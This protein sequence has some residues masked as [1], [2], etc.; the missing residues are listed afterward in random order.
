M[1]VIATGFEGSETLARKPMQVRERSRAAP[2]RR[3]RRPRAPRAPGLRRRHR[4]PAVPARPLSRHAAIAWRAWMPPRRCRRTPLY[5]AHVAAGAKLVPFAGWEMPVAVRGGPRRAPRGALRLRRLRRLAHGR[6]RDRRARRRSALLQRLLSNDVAK[7]EVGGAQYSVLCREDGG[8]LDDLFTYRLADDRYL[9]VTNAANHERDLAWF[10]E[11]AGDFDAEV[12][13]RLAD[14]AMLAVQ[15]PD[16]RAIVAGLARRRAAAAD[17]HRDAR[18]VAGA[19]ALVCGTGYTGEDGVEILVDAGRG[20]GALGRAARR[21]APCPAGLGARDTLRLEVCFHLYGN[22]L[23]E[24]PQPD[25]G[26]ASAGA[27][28]RRRASSAPRRSPRRA[29]TGTAEKLAPFALTG[30]GHPA[31]GQRGRSPAASRSGVVTSGT[32][33]ALA[34]ARDRDGLRARRPR[35]ARDRGRDRRARQAP[36]RRA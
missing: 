13:D 32:L 8:V 17:A 11:H 1:T 31:P 2:G 21:R 30:R 36:R 26:R 14:Y 12:G 24:R 27:A 28:R 16:A 7:I 34:R 3:A 35:R 20:A 23:S 6:D 18:A 29:P 4:R 19:E 33:L 9:T 25:R 5:D 22:D 15:G 10:R